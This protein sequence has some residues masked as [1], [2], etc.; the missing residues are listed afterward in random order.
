MLGPYN[1]M[2]LACHNNS[3]RLGL[4]GRSCT[5]VWAWCW[6]WMMLMAMVEEQQALVVVVV[7]AVV[8]KEDH[9]AHIVL[10]VERC[11]L[12]LAGALIGRY[13]VIPAK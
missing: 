11:C 1:V 5:C 10:V 6:C 9:R 13:D 7:V 4:Q 8:V 3:Y 12:Q 2:A